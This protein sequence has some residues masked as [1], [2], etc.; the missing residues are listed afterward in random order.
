MIVDFLIL[1][2]L[3]VQ[4]NLKKY[5]V[6]LFGKAIGGVKHAV[7]KREFDS[8][9]IL[10]ILKGRVHGLAHAHESKCCF[11]ACAFYSEYASNIIS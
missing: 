8:A 1:G 6:D 7:N 2:C 9:S 3:Y 4:M 10:T 11:F 5:F